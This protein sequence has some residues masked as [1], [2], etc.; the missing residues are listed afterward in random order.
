METPPIHLY[1]SSSFTGKDSI[2]E[3]TKRMKDYPIILYT[4]KLFSEFN[5]NLEGP[6]RS[7]LKNILWVKVSSSNVAVVV[8][9]VLKG[10]NFECLP[11]STNSELKFILSDRRR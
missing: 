2:V 1:H 11:E 8:R 9:E 3:F 4:S 10:L 7:P 5:P 6:K